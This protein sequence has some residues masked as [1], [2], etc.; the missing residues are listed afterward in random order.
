MFAQGASTMK[1]RAED[2]STEERRFAFVAFRALQTLEYLARCAVHWGS[3]V[4]GDGLGV[5]T[6]VLFNGV[7]FNARQ[8]AKLAASTLVQLHR[9]DSGERLG[10]DEDDGGATWGSQEPPRLPPVL[11]GEPLAVISKGAGL[12]KG[13]GAESMEPPGS[14]VTTG[15]CNGGGG[16]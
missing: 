1:S 12:Q 10:G 3:V 2:E 5:I 16:L 11:T 4:E 7:Y 9:H 15:T 6:H 8:L 13:E 14:S